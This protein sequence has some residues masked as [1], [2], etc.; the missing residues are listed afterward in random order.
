MKTHYL[1][2][3][4]ELPNIEHPMIA[5][6]G[7]FDGV[8]LGH[9]Q[10][11]RRAFEIAAEH[12][13]K[14]SVMTFD[15]HPREVLGHQTYSRCLA[16]INK[17]LELLEQLG[18]DY[19]W[20][21][22]FT[23]Q[24]AKVSPE[25]FVYEM[26]VPLH[27]HTVVVGFDFTFGHRGR[28]TAQTLKELCGDKI[29]VEIVPPFNIEGKK[30]SSTFIRDQLQLGNIRQAN[31]YIGRNYSILGKV[32]EGE[33]RGR[34]IGFPTANLALE[35]KYVIPGNGVYAVKFLW[36]GETYNGVMNIG[37]KPTFH[38][39]SEAEPTLEVHILDFNQSIYGE[40]VEVEF[41]E[42]LRKE[43]KFNS[44]EELVQQISADAKK[45]Q[46]ILNPNN[47]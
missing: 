33:K 34:T 16:P 32:V 12:G 2:L 19:T 17:K 38:N 22:Q 18:V 40:E 43:Q 39:D 5:A 13:V 45:A 11:I 27:I 44:L 35:E 42:F 3:E 37:T 26:L 41:V 6:I 10:V 30:V 4:H 21:I 15:P 20:V 31:Q 23:Q 1:S 47:W 9:K 36:R 29:Q 46:S 24:F 28:G 25:E 14:S 7:E 8:H